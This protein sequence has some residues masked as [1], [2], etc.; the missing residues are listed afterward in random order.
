M[1]GLPIAFFIV[2]IV[3]TFVW[4]IS[5]GFT[6]FFSAIYINGIAGSKNAKE[7][8][9]Y[10]NRFKVFLELSRFFYYSIGFIGALLLTNEG[11]LGL[12][13]LPAPPDDLFSY[14][15]LWV[16]YFFIV[17]YYEVVQV[18]DVGITSPHKVT[19]ITKDKVKRDYVLFL[20]GFQTDNYLSEL[21][22][23]R[24]TGDYFSEH[25]FMQ[26]LSILYNAYAIGRP[27]ELINPSGASRI[28]LDNETWQSDVSDLMNKA[29]CIVILVN[30]KPN[31]LWEIAQTDSM[32]KKTV[33][34]INKRTNFDVARSTSPFLNSISETPSS[35]HFY[36]YSDLNG[37]PKCMPYKNTKNDYWSIIEKIRLIMDNDVN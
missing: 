7:S 16:I 28:Y 10:R 2:V 31:C 32:I 34:L 25:R 8:C 13:K 24:M 19:T 9:S 21:Y 20:R 6:D 30:D 33:F 18:M 1:N 12:M 11:F 3:S 37:N 35:S 22:L 36:V 23:D 29:K 14:P 26:R 15:G 27:E 4:L 17:F 5:A